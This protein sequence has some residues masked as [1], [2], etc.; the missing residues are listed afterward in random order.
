VGHAAV[1]DNCALEQIPRPGSSRPTRAYRGSELLPCRWPEE[2]YPLVPKSGVSTFA[3]AAQGKDRSR[4][5]YDSLFPTDTTAEAIRAQA[6]GHGVERH[7]PPQSPVKTVE[8]W[9]L[10]EHASQNIQKSA[11]ASQ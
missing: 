7:R 11:K 1:G 8:Y 10:G 9:R 2:S 5:C 4:L 3:G 6:G